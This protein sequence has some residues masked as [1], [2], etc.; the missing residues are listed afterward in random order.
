MECYH[1]VIITTL[2]T[3]GKRGPGAYISETPNGA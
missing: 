3:V 1:S 2:S